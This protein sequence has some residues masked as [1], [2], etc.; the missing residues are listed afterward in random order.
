MRFRCVLAGYRN[1]IN[2]FRWQLARMCATVHAKK[3]N[4]ADIFAAKNAN[5]INS[6]SKYEATA[7]LK[8]SKNVILLNDEKWLLGMLKHF[9]TIL[10]IYC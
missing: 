2:R 3:C 1:C 4:I 10:A 7:Q 9:I 6:Y 8:D 5:S